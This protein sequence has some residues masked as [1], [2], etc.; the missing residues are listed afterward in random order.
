MKYLHHYFTTDV[1]YSFYFL[2]M[3]KLD[4]T[5]VAFVIYDNIFSV[6]FNSSTS[7]GRSGLLSAV[8]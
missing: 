4:L 8:K 7:T 3:D 6:G 5:T 2:C 1:V